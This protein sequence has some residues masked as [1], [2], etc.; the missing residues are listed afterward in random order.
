M[1]SFRIWTL[2]VLS[3]GVSSGVWAQET[4]KLRDALALAKERNGRVK[5]AYYDLEAARSRA[6]Q[7]SA[8]FL[9]SVTPTYRYLNDKTN[10]YRGSG[11]DSF[12]EEN[13]TQIDVAWRVL[14]SG[15]REWS[16]Q[17]ARRNAESAMF[18]TQDTLRSTLFSVY[19]QFVE[20]LRSQELK[21]VADLQVDRSKVILDQTEAQVQVG[22]SPKKDILQAK[23]DFLNAQVSSLQSKNRVTTAMAGLR[24]AIGWE[25]SR[26][27]PMLEKLEDTG[28]RAEMPL[29]AGVIREG[30]FKRSDLQAQRKS[31]ESLAY[32]VRR[33]EREA[34]L[35]WSLDASFTRR[36]SE[37]VSD[38]RSLTFLVSYPLFDG[39]QSREA[40][41]EARLTFESAKS[42]LAQSE[43]DAASEIEAA[44][45]EAKQNR[46]RYVAAKLALEASQLNYEAAVEAQKAGAAGTNV[47]TVLTAQ[48]SLATAESNLIEALFDLLISEERLKLVTGQPV[49]GENS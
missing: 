16:L 28:E 7:V 22:S 36:F 17:S 31:T 9:P 15:Q 48:V 20:A 21:R 24:S 3:V 33:A 32:A 12:F 19:Q 47:V 4:L 41:R 27:V 14:D 2:V 6:K 26:A 8:T 13:R 29:L 25:E 1:R 30:L 43:R 44:Y 46:E 39:N 40:A 11:F 38:G 35:T 42:R 34:S 10:V 18:D 23:A 45:L 5:A 37:N 49:A